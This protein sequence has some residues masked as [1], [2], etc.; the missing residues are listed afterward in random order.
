MIE[1][2][3][4]I[5]IAGRVQGVGFRAWACLEAARRNIRGWVRNRRDGSVEA[6][7]IAPHDRIE[8]MIEACRRGPSLARVTNVTREPATDD[9]SIGFHECPT[10]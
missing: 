2:A 3:E 7:L 4:R 10:A 6:L 9:G 8:G 1:I 5:V